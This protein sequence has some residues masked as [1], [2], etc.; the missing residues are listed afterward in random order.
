LLPLDEAPTSLCDY[1]KGYDVIQDIFEY[2]GSETIIFFQLDMA[3]MT[4]AEFNVVL[5]LEFHFQWGRDP[6]IQEQKFW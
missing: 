6:S 1:K 5:S 3:L 2:C 4:L